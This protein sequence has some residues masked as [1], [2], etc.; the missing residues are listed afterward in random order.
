MLVRKRQSRV[1][2]G[3]GRHTLALHGTDSAVLRDELNKREQGWCEATYGKEDPLE[4]DALIVTPGGEGEET[5]GVVLADE[6][7]ENSGGFKDVERLWLV[8]AIDEDGDATVGVESDEPRLLL[9][10]RGDVDLLDAEGARSGGCMI[11]RGRLLVIY[12][13]AVDSLEFFEQDGHLVSVGSGRGIE[14]ERFRHGRLVDL[15]W[16]GTTEFI[17][18][19]LGHVS[20]VLANVLSQQH[21]PLLAPLSVP[22]P[23]PPCC[24]GTAFACQASGSRLHLSLSRAA[25]A[26]CFA[27][28]HK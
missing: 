13:V 27:C 14:H 24:P 4:H 9:T 22:P 28:T 23:C 25:H 7:E 20:G 15:Q 2:P 16:E 26:P 8:I 11:H 21:P 3:E 17:V 10:V 12:D 19:W 5:F 6:V 1:Q 18:D